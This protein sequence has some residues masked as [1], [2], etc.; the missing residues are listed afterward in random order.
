MWN[1]LKSI[2]TRLSSGKHDVCLCYSPRYQDCAEQGFP[3]GCYWR[4]TDR[5]DKD[6]ILKKELRPEIIA[7]QS[8][9]HGNKDHPRG[10]LI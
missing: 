10:G 2:L 7:L 6:F 8:I 5:F 9:R 1:F 4:D 3:H